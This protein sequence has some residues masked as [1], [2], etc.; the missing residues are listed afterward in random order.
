MAS[1]R[2][3]NGKRGAKNKRTE[4]RAT[5]ETQAVKLAVG[6]E[7]ILRLGHPPASRKGRR[8]YI[9]LKTVMFTTRGSLEY[10]KMCATGL[11]VSGD[12]SETNSPRVSLIDM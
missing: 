11:P 9:D 1:R 10:S 7:V 12:A 2:K 8:R 6:Q 4:Q 3:L 5:Q